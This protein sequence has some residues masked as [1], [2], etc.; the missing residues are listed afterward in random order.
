MLEALFCCDDTDEVC[1]DYFSGRHQNDHKSCNEYYFGPHNALTELSYNS[2][3]Y[4]HSNIGDTN[5]FIE[6]KIDSSEA[7]EI[8]AVQVTDRQDCCF[9]RFRD[10]EVLVGERYKH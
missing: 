2:T 3:H 9:K 5:P 4:Q 7:K 10:V 8:V 1:V 6:F